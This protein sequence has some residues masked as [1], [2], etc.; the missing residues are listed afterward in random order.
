MSYR[1]GADI[2]GTF[3]DLILSDDGGKTF[4][5]GKVL[6][7]PERPDDAVV[8]GVE[9]VLDQARTRADEISHV[10]HGT[11]LFANAII[12][13]KG[14]KTALVT[15]KGFRDAIE[16][17]R[18][19]RYDM[20]DLYMR[21]P[22]PL[23]PRYLRFE[24]DERILVDGSIRKPLTDDDVWAVVEAL[25]RAE[26][27]A[28]AVSLI[29]AY[30]ND[31]HERRVGEILAEALPD[32]A[33]T[34]SSDLVPEIREYD[35]TS[36]TLVNV[37]VKRIAENYLGRLR[38][39]LT[40]ESRIDGGLFVMQSN[41]GV[42]E[43]ETAV[44]YPVRLIESGPAAGALAAA[45]YGALLG[46]KDLLSFDMGGTTAKACV[47]SD[48]EPSIAPEFEVGRQYQF[49]K[50]SGLPVKVPVIEMI[51]IGT[52]GGSIARVD[53]MQRLQVG[54]DSAGA[55]PG[56]VAYALGGTEPTVTDADLVLGYLDPNFFL[57]GAMSLDPEAARDAVEEKIGNPLGLAVTEAAWGMHQLAN[58]SMAS[59]A[60][61]HAIERGKDVS[62]FSLFAFGGAGPVHAFGVASILRSPL[63]I[64]PFGAGVMS[65]IGFLTA[66]LSL[67]FVRT[68]PGP[69]DQL[70]WNGAAQVVAEMEAEGK[71]VLGRTID[72]DTIRFRR[73]ADMRYRKQ[74]YEIRV[75]IPDG[76]LGADCRDSIQD[77]FETAYRAIYGHTVADTAIDV[78]SWR[79]VASGPKP[80]VILPAART[81][82]GGGAETA[83]KG[84]RRVYLPATKDFDEIPVYDRYALGAGIDFEG[85]AIV[86][87]RE[88]TVVINGAA[89]VQVD[90]ANNLLVELARRA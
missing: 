32:V 68:F 77:N 71:L 72:A 87:E 4:Q 81:S 61:I 79:V 69:L 5:V 34:L 90:D 73:F 6:T 43:V 31:L 52:G 13:R 37:Y 2:G 85:P 49:K 62:K 9:Q 51:E 84:T 28:V 58:E 42:C 40:E 74:G 20:Y 23:A 57:G 36:T 50:G 54:P 56:P 59:A 19:H 17:A 78:V 16:I 46:H 11:T 55:N 48:G 70:D 41:G 65:A 80:E 12:E 76:P 44:R 45:Q 30:V 53:A 38:R 15:T 47:I 10:V 27:E 35:R 64:Y 8:M 63:V 67:D 88:S 75:P 39:R 24:L 82:A 7:T 18:E 86:E 21:R 25:R 29:H 83:R 22:A 3:T 60:R 26:V 1:I 33:L 66:P 14:A 89:A